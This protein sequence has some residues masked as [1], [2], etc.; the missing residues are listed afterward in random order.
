MEVDG[1]VEGNR[2][3]YFSHDS[4]PFDVADLVKSATAREVYELDGEQ[5]EREIEL[6]F[7]KISFGLT[8]D[9]PT[10]GLSPEDVYGAGGAGTTYRKVPLYIYYDGVLASDDLESGVAYI[11]IGVKGDANL[12]GSVTAS[13]SAAVLV[14]AASIGSGVR[15]YLTA[16]AAAGDVPT[17]EAKEALAWFLS[18]IDTESTNE[19]EDSNNETIDS[20]ELSAKDGGYIAVY[21]AAVGAGMPH[22]WAKNILL[23]KD[24]PKFT[25][26][27]YETAPDGED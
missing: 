2:N 20:A 23:E 4:R 6:D 13:D 9:G 17:S 25:K 7:T 11:Y 15:A 18:D 5:S 21:A 3:F 16:D 10:E 14:Y 12:D 19:G 8:T 1:D 24:L 26:A 22:N 27:I